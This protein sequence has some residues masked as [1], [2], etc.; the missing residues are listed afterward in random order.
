[1]GEGWQKVQ[2]S[3]IKYKTPGDIMYSTVTKVNSIVFYI[4]KLQRVDL[5]C[6]HHK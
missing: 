5:K 1:M 3:V 6:S 4:T 2:T